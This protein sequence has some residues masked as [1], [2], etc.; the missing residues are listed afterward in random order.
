MQINRDMRRSIFL[1]LRMGKLIPYGQ[2]F[3]KC[4]KL[5]LLQLPRTVN[6]HLCYII[7]NGMLN[8]AQNYKFDHVLKVF[9]RELFKNTNNTRCHPGKHFIIQYF[10][11]YL[12]NS[13]R[14]A[15]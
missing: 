12:V 2:T 4:N 14:E 11:N 1:I 3:H 8:S 5:E 10:G 7:V 6:V 9:F 13:S 15:I